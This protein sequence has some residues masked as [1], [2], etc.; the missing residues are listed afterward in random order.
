MVHRYGTVGKRIDME[1][2]TTSNFSSIDLTCQRNDVKQGEP[3]RYL[4]ITPAKDEEMYIGK[5]LNSLVSQTLLPSKWIIINDGSVDNTERIIISYQKQYSFIELI[6]LARK[7]K[8]AAG[9]EGVLSHA[10][11]RVNLDDYDYIARFDADIILQNDYIENIFNEFGKD[12]YLGIAGGGLYVDYKGNF[13]L[14]EEP[15]YHVR[16]ALKMYRKQCFS[17]INGLQPYIGWDTIDEV[18]AWTKGWKTKSFFDY[19]VIHQRPTGGGI[20]SL[21]VYWQR[22][23]SDYYT[24]SHPLFVFLK[25]IKLIGISLNIPKG[26]SFYCGY[27]C[28][29]I[30][31]LKRIKNKSFIKTRRTQQL[32]RIFCHSLSKQDKSKHKDCDHHHIKA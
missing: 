14:E 27:L 31:R 3:P 17:D 2:V 32:R 7:D 13:K 11:K 12:A 24:C 22:G 6:S 8:R 16:G 25:A 19:R 26:V 4:L 21:S 18:A 9:G 23:K 20:S 1:K 10:L 29:F 5:M 15:N 28:C 30:Q